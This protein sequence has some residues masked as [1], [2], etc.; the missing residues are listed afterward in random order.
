LY[1]E[2][3]NS[4]IIKEIEKELSLKQL[5]VSSLN[6]YF[7][8]RYYLGLDDVANVEELLL[9]LLPEELIQKVDYDADKKQ[10]VVACKEENDKIKNILTTYS[11]GLIKEERTC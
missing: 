11:D 2:N 7:T 8:P 9:E 3:V 10:L 1:V 5:N 4:E 6:S